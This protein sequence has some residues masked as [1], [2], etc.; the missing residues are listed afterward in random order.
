M[1]ALSLRGL[2]PQR[3]GRLPGIP[4]RASLLVSACSLPGNL[5]A[6]R[7]TRQLLPVSENR[8][9]PGNYVVAATMSS[10]VRRCGNDVVR[11]RPE[12]GSGG[13]GDADRAEV[14]ECAARKAVPRSRDDRGRMALAEVRT[15]ER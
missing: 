6:F 13:D 4:G 10:G 3:P 15:L 1:F 7:P 14:Q 5:R 8:S 9:P 12:A 11:R 2:V